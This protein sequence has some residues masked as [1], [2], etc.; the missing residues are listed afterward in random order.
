MHDLAP[1]FIPSKG[2]WDVATTWKQ[3]DLM[4]ITRYRVIVEPQ[5]YKQYRSVLPADK[6]LTLDMDFKR[7][8]DPCDGIG[9]DK[10]PRTG[11]G[12]ARNYGWHIAEQEGAEYHWI[13]DDNIRKF[14]I[15]NNNIKYNV[16]FDTLAKVEAFVKK[17]ENVNMAGMQ[18]SKFVPRKQKVLPLI[19]NTRIFSCN[20]IK[21]ETK[22]R[23]RGRYNEDVILSLDMLRSGFCTLLFQSY[24]CDKMATQVMKGGNTDELYRQGTEAKSNLLKAVY[25]D[26]VELV[27]R[28]GR[29]HHRVDYGKWKYNKLI[30]KL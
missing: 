4:G 7:R 28:Y 9:F 18:Y 3:L 23:W 1:I 14:Q 21:T 30:P 26:N 15:L 24:I 27:E 6:I 29:H 22:L 13:I 11:S 19:I 8:Y 5:E 12:P 20:L 17:Y 2:R 16:N 25:P 10:N